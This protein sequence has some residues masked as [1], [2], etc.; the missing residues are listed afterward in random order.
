MVL[1]IDLG[2]RTVKAVFLKNGEIEDSQIALGGSDPYNTAVS[3][4]KKYPKCPVV[5]T[6]YGRHILEEEWADKVITE[7]KAHAI[8]ARF[9][10][11]SCRTVIDMGGQDSK[12]IALDES[13]QFVNFQMNDKCAAGTGKFLEVM[14]QALGYPIDTF[15]RVGINE[16]RPARISSMCTVFAESEVI[17]LVSKQVR[18]EAIVR[19]LHEAIA[20]RIASMVNRVGVE[21]DV[22]FSGGVAR[23]P[24]MI[25]LLEKKLKTKLKVADAPDI[26]GALG[27]A[28]AGESLNN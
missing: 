4:L 11:P 24:T 12:V 13:G 2:S 15:A 9:F 25:A 8:G 6:G 26:I 16:T 18:K 19:G 3:L 23:N 7:I 17:S 21:K 28:I 20:G 10:F 27:A 14:A 1:G 22:V 5:A